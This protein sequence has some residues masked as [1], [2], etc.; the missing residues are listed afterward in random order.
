MRGVSCTLLHENPVRPAL[1]GRGVQTAP[2]AGAHALGDQ[3][4]H[5]VEDRP[6]P[7]VRVAEQSVNALTC[8]AGM[9]R[10]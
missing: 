6:L 8:N 2:L 3:I 5:V 9:W 7:D 4:K 10:I 1:Q